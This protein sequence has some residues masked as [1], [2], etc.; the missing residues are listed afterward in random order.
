MS[1]H[2][3]K[4]DPEDFGTAEIIV[5]GGSVA[6]VRPQDSPPDEWAVM[7]IDVVFR[8]PGSRRGGRVRGSQAWFDPEFRS[9]SVA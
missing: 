2:R 5:N 4:Q 1:E 6:V 3:A 7:T 8:E 9:I